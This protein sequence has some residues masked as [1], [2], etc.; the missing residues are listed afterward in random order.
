MAKII[1]ILNFTGLLCVA[2]L[3]GLLGGLTFDLFQ[4]AAAAHSRHTSPASWAV[5]SSDV[6]ATAN[7]YIVYTTFIFVV[8][9]LLVTAVGLYFAKWFGAVKEREIQD[10]MH[11]FFFNLNTDST[12]ADSF[13][14]KLFKHTATKERLESLVDAKVKDEIK[15]RE[16]DL[17]DKEIGDLSVQLELE[18]DSKN[19]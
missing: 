5:S 14:K 10:N 13:T 1:K 17:A 6:M 7:T 15:N 4:D 3:A 11:D 12:L 2:Y 8:I 9:T 19:E 16:H 18:E